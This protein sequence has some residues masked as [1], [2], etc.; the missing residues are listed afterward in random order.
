LVLRLLA[1]A[2]IVLT[3]IASQA[4]PHTCLNGYTDSCDGG[5]GGAKICVLTTTVVLNDTVRCELDT[6][7]SGASA[8][9]YAAEVGSLYEVFGTDAKGNQFCCAETPSTVANN[10]YLE[11]GGGP[12]GDLIDLQYNTDYVKPVTTR[13]LTVAIY[14]YGGVDTIK[15][16]PETS[17][18][19]VEKL[20]GGLGDDTIE[21]RAGADDLYGQ[22]GVDTLRGGDGDDDIVGGADSDTCY[23]DAGNDYIWGDG[24]IDTLWGGSGDDFMYGGSD[25]DVLR[26]EGGVDTMHGG[27]EADIMYGGSEADTLCGDED[28]STGDRLFGEGGD[29]LLWGGQIG[30]LFDQII[31]GPNTDTC[32]D[33][34][35]ALVSCE[36]ITATRPAACAI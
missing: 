36:F 27:A 6:L 8:V 3:P 16:S 15:G 7:G 19:Y 34:S 1:F 14:G 2:G 13:T 24:G 18:V 31:G 29:D 10:W 22:E 17:N 5:L 23:G 26:G 28:G 30:A 9:T 12:L 4:Y 33:P 20:W 21:G 35:E 25:A 11:I 32:G